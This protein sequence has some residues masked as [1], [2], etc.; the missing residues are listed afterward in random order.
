M[1]SHAMEADLRLYLQTELT[2]RCKRNPRYSLRA[3]AEYLQMDASSISQIISGK[4]RASTKVIEKIAERL[5]IHPEQKALFLAAANKKAAAAAQPS[6]DYQLLAQDTFHFISDWYHYAILELISV[7][8][9]QN[10][11]SWIARMLGITVSE[12][13]AAV[14]RMVRLELIREE[15]GALV[16][17]HKFVTNFAPGMTSAALK[18]LQRDIVSKAL[19]AIDEVPQEEKDITSMTMAID[20][21]KLDDARK[22]IAKFRREL[23]AHM[24]DGRQ[25][26]VYNLGI[27]LYPVSK[28]ETADEN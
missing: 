8:G 19:R 1:N 7:D 16:R 26:R 25:S 10:K 4:R 23:C 5:S 21:S 14:E 11:P 3:F 2:Q 28:K 9:F 6:A 17:S 12:A 18:N 13:S 22:M 20:V 27:Q 24:E 15:E